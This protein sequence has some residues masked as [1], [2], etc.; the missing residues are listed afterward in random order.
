MKEYLK[1]ELEKIKQAGLY[2]QVR[3]V[4]PG[5]LNFSTNNYLSLADDPRV[6]AA[7]AEAAIKY[8]SGG[9]SS[10]LIAGTIELHAALESA[11]AGYKGA[12]AALVYPT[13]FQTN[14]GVISALMGEGDCVIMDK[15]NHASLWD[16][17]KLSKARV[18][19]YEHRDMSA[20]EK[21]LARS[22][23]YKKTL[24]VT[25]SLFSM[26]GDLAPLQDITALAKK[27]G[28]WTMI[29]E[30][31]AM[32]IFEEK[33][34][35]DIV[36]GTLSKALG[37]Q[38]GFVCGPKE[39]IEFLVNRSRSFI[40]TT[41]LAPACAG[42]AL[43]ALRIIRAEPQRGKSLLEKSAALRT[44]LKAKGFDTGDSESQ[45][46]PVMTGDVAPT[47]A[48]SE[49]LL[50]KGIFVPA[51]R[52]PTVPEGKCRLRISLNYGHSEEDMDKLV[53]GLTNV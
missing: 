49:K 17:S 1:G 20:L 5:V 15:L 18:F 27:Y 53:R 43:E 29:D 52:P 22:K 23:E 47:L 37:S 50:S 9:T 4:A 3:T 19:V 21:V 33:V 31:H 38:G 24:V 42:A 36:M 10:R 45:I 8:G 14:V 35:I 32:G 40:Y 7:A 16:A 51:I 2:R 39:L 13:G 6:K 46:I 26:D 25:D 34:K 44:R 28:A 41:A 30:A 11:L 48:L 12:G